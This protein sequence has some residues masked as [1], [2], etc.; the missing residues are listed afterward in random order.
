[1]QTIFG[2]R[3][4]SRQLY[5]PRRIPVLS[6]QGENVYEFLIVVK[7]EIGILAKI[8]SI[9]FRHRINLLSHYGYLFD[10]SSKKFVQTVFCDF[11]EA[12]CTSE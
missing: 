12:D 7:D 10:P 2:E 11:G 8:A 3:I 6:P 5:Y 9:F 1:M 4:G